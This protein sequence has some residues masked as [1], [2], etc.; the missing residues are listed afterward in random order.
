MTKFVFGSIGI[1][2]LALFGLSASHTSVASFLPHSPVSSSLDG[3]SLIQTATGAIGP[4]ADRAIAGFTANLDSIAD[5]GIDFVRRNTGSAR[6][7]LQSLAAST[8]AGKWLP[9]S[10]MIWIQGGA[11]VAANATGNEANHLARKVSSAGRALQSPNRRT[12]AGRPSPNGAE[13]GF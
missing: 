7:Q 6:I 9:K 10:A 12:A 3:G 13:A 2:A 4:A 8:D 11:Q 5:S 1:G